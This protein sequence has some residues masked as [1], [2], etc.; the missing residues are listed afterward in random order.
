[1]Y[2]RYGNINTIGNPTSWTQAYATPSTNRYATT[3]GCSNG[4]QYDNDGNLSCDFFH[5]YTWDGTNQLLSVDGHAILR[6][7]FDRVVESNGL[8]ILYST[9]GK[10]GFVNGQT[11][12]KIRIPLPGGGQAVYNGGTLAKFNHPDW[13]GNIRVA[14]K[15]ATQ[16]LA[17]Q[18]EYT[19][20]GMPYNNGTVGAAG[21]SFNQSFGD[22]FDSHE[23]DALN[24]ELHPVQGRW[25]QPDP[26]GLSAVDSTNPQTWNRYAYV[27]NNPL[28]FIDPTGLEC[29]W[30]DGSYDSSDDPNTGKRAACHDAG[31]TWFD[32]STFS[33]PNGDWSPNADAGLADEIRQMQEGNTAA[34]LYAQGTALTPVQSFLRGW[35]SNLSFLVGF[36]SGNGQ[37]N[38]QYGP[39]N[40][41]TAS[42][43]NSKAINQMMEKVLEQCGTSSSGSSFIG[44]SQAA[45]NATT[46][47]G[48]APDPLVSPT[49]FQLGAF[50]YDW[51]LSSGTVNF[52]VQNPATLNS[53]LYHVPAQVGISN[54]ASGPLGT[55]NQTFNF[56]LDLPFYAQCAG[57]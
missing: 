31:G 33:A 12:T 49:A 18:N 35:T 8:E 45:N 57:Q 21:P 16:T 25:I 14:S 17:G 6:D 13:Q 19:P 51:Q 9:I 46:F 15:A 10:L 36:L 38:Q 30:D 7:A 40:V 47:S 26:A 48:G 43:L 28:R 29:A 34:T 5:A 37:R 24:R 23:Y 50:T 1:M 32:P 4:V 53:F 2:D 20:F 52:A 54:P 42:L 41:E 56:S 44:T 3:G 22:V 11:M 55:I 39:G 27:L